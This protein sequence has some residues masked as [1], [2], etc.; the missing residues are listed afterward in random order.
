MVG[1]TLLTI[2]TGWR[3]VMYII[4]DLG[5]NSSIPRS[6]F[7]RHCSKYNLDFLTYVLGEA[8]LKS[9]FSEKISAKKIGYL[10]EGL[11]SN[12]L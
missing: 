2:P 1:E 11:M 10:R 12:I 6:S 8:F 3:R 9:K 7:R 5:V 4:I